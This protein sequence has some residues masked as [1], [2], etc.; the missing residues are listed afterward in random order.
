MSF[1]CTQ[2]TACGLRCAFDWILIV[3][4]VYEW[5]E[6]LQEEEG[7]ALAEVVQVVMCLYAVIKPVHEKDGY[8]VEEGG[9]RGL[10]SNRGHRQVAKFNF[11]YLLGFR[12]QREKTEMCIDFI[13]ISLNSLLEKPLLHD[14][15]FIVL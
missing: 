6:V 3:R 1:S 11:K 13:I 10:L 2:L 14:A 5:E 8:E 12:I 4:E 15:I 7:C 9:A